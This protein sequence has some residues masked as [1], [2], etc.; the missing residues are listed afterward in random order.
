MQQKTVL[1]DAAGQDD[2]KPFGIERPALIS[3]H[4]DQGVHEAHGSRAGRYPVPDIIQQAADQRLP[5]RRKL[6][7]GR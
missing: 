2:R 3:R 1:E 4:A 7:P 6:R 5:R